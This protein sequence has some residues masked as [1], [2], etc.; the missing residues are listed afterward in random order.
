MSR[1]EAVKRQG[2]KIGA[3]V[4]VFLGKP[5]EAV[6]CARQANLPTE[7]ILGI[8]MESH[9]S[10]A[11]RALM[12]SRYDGMN[13]HLDVRKHIT[14]AL[15]HNKD[16]QT[17]INRWEDDGGSSII[18]PTDQLEKL[19]RFGCEVTSPSHFKYNPRLRYM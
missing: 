13:F 4:F 5:A 18:S 3:D 11:N 19:I 14:L 8:V 17:E 12:D 6:W 1:L 7:D 2:F 9:R 10:A 16:T 15:N